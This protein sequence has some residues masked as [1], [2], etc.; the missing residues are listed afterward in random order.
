MWA[1]AA[2][3]AYIGFMRGWNKEII[4]TSGIILGLFALFEFDDVLQNLLVQLPDD[5]KFVVR[6]VIFSVIVYF[7]YQTRALIGAAA[8]RAR[9]S[10]DGRDSL[11]S[12]VL[13]G[14]VGLFNGYLIWGS[15]WYWLHVTNYPLSPYISAPLPNSA[16]ANFV[17][18]LPLY[19]LA[20]GPGGDGNLLA[21]AMIALF[22]VVLIVI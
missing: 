1:M 7:S 9:G 15:L 6:A 22:L 16:S 10:G 17:E 21:A 8:E 13:G 3:F 11:Q 14:I 19:V 18:S 2:I 12:S 4:A 20:G 5:Q